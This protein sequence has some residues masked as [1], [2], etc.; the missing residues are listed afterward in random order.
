MKLGIMKLVNIYN[1]IRD[2]INITPSIRKVNKGVR[3]FVSPINDVVNSIC[4]EILWM[5]KR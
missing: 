2:P 5:K 1:G 4:R 3:I